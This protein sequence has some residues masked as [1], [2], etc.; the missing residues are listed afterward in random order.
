MNLTLS[1]DCGKLSCEPDVDN[2]L[3]LDLGRSKLRDSACKKA[4]FGDT[5]ARVGGNNADGGSGAGRGD[6]GD[7]PSSAILVFSILSIMVMTSVRRA[8]NRVSS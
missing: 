8:L 3:L 1:M 4:R 2:V 5:G 6:G 7:L